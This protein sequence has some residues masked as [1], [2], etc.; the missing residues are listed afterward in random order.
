L[1]LILRRS[2]FERKN[3]LNYLSKLNLN[4][5]IIVD[6]GIYGSVQKSIRKLTKLKLDGYYILS[7]KHSK[8]H[9]FFDNNSSFFDFFPL[10]EIFFNAP[11]GSYL[12]FD[13]NGRCIKA[14]KTKNQNL[15]KKKNDLYLGVRNFIKEIKY[16][17]N[18]LEIK[19][20]K[21]NQNLIETLFLNLSSKDVKISNKILN[22]LYLDNKYVRQ[23]DKLYKIRKN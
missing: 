22:L 12:Y 5:S 21:I 23:S 2:N 14:K 19:D 17:K 9:S 16:F 6:G 8:Q 1:E 10:I 15:F 3:Y 18:N 7:R 20:N 11:H 13:N 4:N